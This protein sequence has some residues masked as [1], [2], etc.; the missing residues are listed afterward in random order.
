M[1]EP[2]PQRHPDLWVTIAEGRK[3]WRFECPMHGCAYRQAGQREHEAFCQYR[4]SR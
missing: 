2:K 1:K 3:N 4:M